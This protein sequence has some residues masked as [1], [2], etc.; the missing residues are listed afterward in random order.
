MRKEVM[1]FC[2]PGPLKTACGLSVDGVIW[3]ASILHVSCQICLLS[4]AGRSALRI[5]NNMDGSLDSLA[6]AT[7]K[8]TITPSISFSK[9]VLEGRP[10]V[11][12]TTITI[13]ELLFQM[14]VRGDFDEVS[15][16]TGLEDGDITDAINDLSQLFDCDWATIRGE[17]RP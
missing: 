15:A 12:G 10:R 14:A 8:S 7:V 3:T 4:D 11:A 13:S 1:H 9:N 5:A 17:E 2:G 16:A 6:S